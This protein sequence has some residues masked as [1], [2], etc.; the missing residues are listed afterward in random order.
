MFKEA[1]HKEWVEARKALLEKEKA[2]TKA[3]DELASL[4]RQL[5]HVK[6]E[7]YTFEGPNGKL[8]LLD[9][10]QGRKQLIIYHFMFSPTSTT[11]CVGCSFFADNIPAYLQHLHSR[12]ATLVLVSRA[13]YDV[14]ARFKEPMGW[15]MPWYSSFEWDFNYDFQATND[16]AVA[17]MMANWE[18]AEALRERGK[19]GHIEGKQS[20]VSVFI[21]GPGGGVYHT[22]STF[23]RGVDG[24]L[25]TNHLLD[26]TP[27]GRQDWEFWKYHDEYEDD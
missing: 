8:N 24:F 16:S 22:Y 13:P 18:S 5:P 20:G 2:L 9:L 23:A 25:G 7:K 15:T 6:V 1:T 3:S 10:F 21:V 19:G 14:I 12:N 27:L 26:V 17:P 11:G 4:R